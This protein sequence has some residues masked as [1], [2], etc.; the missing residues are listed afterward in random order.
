[1]MGSFDYLDNTA[2]EVAGAP[3]QGQQRLDAGRT[4]LRRFEFARANT[5][6]SIR[7]STQQRERIGADPVAI[8]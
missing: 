7:Q 3:N 5:C 4:V 1:M 6:T 2:S 8:G